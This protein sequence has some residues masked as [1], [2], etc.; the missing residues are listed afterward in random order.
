ML[1]I[2]QITIKNLIYLPFSPPVLGLFVGPGCPG[3]DDVIPHTAP[4][5]FKST[6][7]DCATFPCFIQHVP[8]L[9]FVHVKW[10]QPLVREH[11]GPQFSPVDW[12]LAKFCPPG[13]SQSAAQFPDCQLTAF[14]FKIKF[15][16]FNF[17]EK[18]RLKK[19]LNTRKIF[20]NKCYLLFHLWKQ[21]KAL[22]K[23]SVW[24][25]F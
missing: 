4:C 25:F 21:S 23:V 19:I 7:F 3:T 16:K 14:V 20:I 10:V 1:W 6:A 2:H 13:K 18:N 24:T 8:P 17:T 12:A 9:Y 22:L 5:P 15:I 11:K